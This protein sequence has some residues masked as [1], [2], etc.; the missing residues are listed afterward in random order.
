MTPG[1][2]MEIPTGHVRQQFIATRGNRNLD[3]YQPVIW[4]MLT[5]WRPCAVAR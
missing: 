4:L 1:K 2:N 5:N 3:L